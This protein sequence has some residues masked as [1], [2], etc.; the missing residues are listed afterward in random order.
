MQTPTA[1]LFFVFNS[2]CNCSARYMGNDPSPF[3]SVWNNPDFSVRIC[4]VPACVR[5][6]SDAAQLCAAPE[7]ALCGA[8]LKSRLGPAHSPQVPFRGTSPPQ[9]CVLGSPGVGDPRVPPDGL[10]L[11]LPSGMS[12]TTTGILAAML[13]PPNFVTVQPELRKLLISLFEKCC[14]DPACLLRAGIY[15]PPAGPSAQ[16]GCC[17]W[18]PIQQTPIF[19]RALSEGVS[20]PCFPQGILSLAGCLELPAALQ[21][22]WVHP[23]PGAEHG[24]GPDPR[25]WPVSPP[26]K[27]T[28]SLL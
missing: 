10:R 18:Y 25:G 21:P 12:G 27:H 8:D 11:E 22:A 13:H 15:P 4:L 9:V 20:V 28:I 26:N 14:I 17:L 5:P 7:G 6:G 3:V 2:P 1:N 23:L 24:A 16:R 19:S